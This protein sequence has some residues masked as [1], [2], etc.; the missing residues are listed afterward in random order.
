MNLNPEAK[1]LAGAATKF[2]T[3]N[4][5][6]FKTPSAIPTVMT[7]TPSALTQFSSKVGSKV[8]SAIKTT[9]GVVGDVERSVT[10]P[11][12]KVV[13]DLDTL[14]ASKLYKQLQDTP[15]HKKVGSEWEQLKNKYHE[16][17]G[18]RIARMGDGIPLKPVGKGAS[19]V[20]GVEKVKLTQL[21]SYVPARTHNT[22]YEELDEINFIAQ[23]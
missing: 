23:N 13:Q 7:H 14:K 16:V 19:G 20:P 3:H 10:K 21:A 12:R 6:K 18:R 5:Q 11:L 17:Q 2:M 4:V 22:I 1:F 8:T 15:D 9:K